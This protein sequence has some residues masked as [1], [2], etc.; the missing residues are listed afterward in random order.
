MGPS[1]ASTSSFYFCVLKLKK[2]KMG[3]LYRSSFAASS[4]GYQSKATGGAHQRL[5]LFLLFCH[6]SSPL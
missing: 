4:F 2:A 1:G 5:F 6:L 3:S